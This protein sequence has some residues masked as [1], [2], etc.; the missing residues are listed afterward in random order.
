MSEQL[1]QILPMIIFLYGANSFLIREK[2][3]AIKDK[4]CAQNPDDFGLEELYGDE[5]S[6][7]EEMKSKLAASS[8]FSS[9][10]LIIVKNIFSGTDLDFRAALSEQLAKLSA[11]VTLILTANSNPDKREKLYKNLIKIAKCQ[12]F[13][14]LE[15]DEILD[16]TLER[17]AL[18]GGGIER[19][20]SRKLLLLIG[21]DLESIA[22]EI[23]KLALFAKS[24]GRSEIS[25]SDADEMVRAKYAPQIFPFIESVV[26]GKSKEAFEVLE[27][28]YEVGENENYLI[29]MITYQYRTL[30]SIAD[31]QRRGVA[32][33]LIAKEAGI[34]PFVLS[35]SLPILERYSWEKLLLA[36][37]RILEADSSMKNGKVEPRLALDLLVAKL[38]MG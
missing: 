6:N 25:E 15:P 2:L 27:E 1:Q 21:D 28:F 33:N 29:S 20:A 12:E 8:L 10:R 36:Y 35:K 24:R 34:H 22:N 7:I 31:F 13:S 9:K 11:D 38:S 16:W 3:G 4:Y 32:S 14:K 5:I 37:Q 17:A 19:A 23:D 30:I 18:L 26:S